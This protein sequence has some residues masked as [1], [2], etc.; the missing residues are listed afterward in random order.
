MNEKIYSG[1]T[2]NEWQR[3]NLHAIDEFESSQVTF[4][5]TFVNLYFF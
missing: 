3:T 1:K 4:D 2:S 5:F